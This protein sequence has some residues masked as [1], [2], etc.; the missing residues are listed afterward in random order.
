MLAQFYTLY[1]ANEDVRGWLHIEG[2]SID[3]PVMQSPNPRT[4]PHYY[5][6]HS[7]DRQP[8]LSGHTIFQHLCGLLF[9][10]VDQPQPDHI[11]QQ[12]RQFPYPDVQ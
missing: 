10:S 1:S 5:A 4:D 2:T 11:W 7:F 6:Q 9:R 8:S 12:H 3:Y